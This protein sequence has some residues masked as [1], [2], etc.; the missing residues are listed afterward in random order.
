MQWS[1]LLTV[2]QIE[3]L[4]EKHKMFEARVH[5]GFLSE[6]HDLQRINCENII[7]Y[8]LHIDLVYNDPPE[9]QS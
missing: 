7:L 6:S 3:L 4:D 2:D 9:F 8:N 5:V 1:Q